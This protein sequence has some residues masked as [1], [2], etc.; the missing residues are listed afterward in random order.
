MA[1]A[2]LAYITN[3][4]SIEFQKTKGTIKKSYIISKKCRKN[5]GKKDK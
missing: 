4:K 1:F 3:L 2:I 5:Q